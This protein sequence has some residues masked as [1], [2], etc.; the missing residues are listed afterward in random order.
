MYRERLLQALEDIEPEVVSHFADHLRPFIKSLRM[1]YVLGNGGSQANA[2]HAVL[3]FKQAGIRAMDVMAELAMFSALANDYSYASGPRML[4]TKQALPQDGLLV[5]S[6]SGDSENVIMALA[7]AKQIGMTTLGLLG[8]GGGMALE[9]CRL[10]IVLK[11]ADYGPVEDA[12]S[13]IIHELAELLS[14][15]Q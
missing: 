4:L 8:F 10:A 1:L 9:L 5:I 6:G 7:Q 12:H 15:P 14:G 2:N 11:P 3:H 13:A